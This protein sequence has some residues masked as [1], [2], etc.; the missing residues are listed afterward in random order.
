[1][2]LSA[3]W[4]YPTAF[5]CLLLSG[6]AGLVYQVV[7]ARYLGLVLGHASYA[8]V[9]VLVAFMGGLALG[10][11]WLG[12]YADRVRRPLSLYAWL[13]IG[14]A[15]YAL[16]FPIY[17]ERC[18]QM[19]VALGSGA[20]PGSPWLLA[21]KFVVSFALILLPT[22]L[23][24][25]T[26]PIL[27][28]LV[29]RSLGELRARVAGLYFINSLGAVFGVLLAEFW[30]IPGWGLDATL[31]GGATLN[32]AVGIIS[33][34]VASG[35]REMDIARLTSDSTREPDAGSSTTPA[36]D[37]AEEVYSPFELR[38]AIA[39][40][41]I[42]GFVAMLYEVV[43]TRVL[44]LVLGSST[45]A[46]S[47]MLVTFIAGITTG[48]W[49]VGRW[50]SLRRTFDA[51]GW[52][53]LALSLS[54]LVS[55]FFYHLLPYY[56]AK[57]GTMITRE[58]EH[59]WLYELG[60][61]TICFAVMFGPALCLGMTLPLAS[62]V[63]TS[64]LARTGRSVGVVFSVNTVGTVLGAALSGLVF[65]PWLGL[66][67]TFALGVGLNLIIALIVLA[68]RN[69][70]LR[71]VLVWTSPLV[72]L[73]LVGGVHRTLS[74]DWER[75]F[76]LGL[77]RETRLPPSVSDYV[78]GL[79]KVNVRF[80]R[81]GAG[82]TVV[83]HGWTNP[84]SR[85][86]EITLR[87]NGKADASSRGDVPTQLLSG[88]LPVLLKGDVKDVMVVGIGS[89]MTCG[90]ILTH[91]SV[92]TID[93]VEIS[94]EVRDAA[95][96]EFA[97]FNHG[98]LDDPR[99]R[100]VLD[101]AKSFLATSGR[102]YD[103]IVSEP[104]NPWMA[105]VAGVFSLEYYEACR[106]SL[107]AGGLMAQWVQTYE[108]ND[109]T[110]RMVLATFTS[111]FPFASVWQPMSGDLILIGSTSRLPR[112][113]AALQRRFD[114]PSVTRDLQRV[115]I[116]RLPVLL[117]LQLI[118]ED[119]T[120]FIAGEDTPRHSDFFPTLEYLAGKAFFVRER[121]HL[122]ETLD[123]TEL[124]RPGT[125]LGDYIK[126]HP[127]NLTDA[128]SYA[129]LHTS[130]GIPRAA[131][132]RSI[133]EL[134]RQLAPGE[135][136]PAEY[137]AKL[138]Y[139]L[140]VSELEAQ[141]MAQA[142]DAILTNATRQVEPLRIY[143]RHLMHAYRYLRSAYYIPPHEELKSVLERLVELDE[144][145]RRSHLLRLAEIAW[146]EGDDTN[147]FRLA[148]EAFRPGQD[149]P[150]EVGR[151]NFDNRAP[152]RV[153]FLII[154]TLW[155]AQRFAEARAWCEAARQGGFLDPAGQYYTER[156][157]MVVRKVELTEGQ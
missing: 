111:V 140:P 79:K 97:P 87:V 20:T 106:A 51:F 112:D 14:I 90:A 94:P 13:E 78:D 154:E 31:L 35:T 151:F 15:V 83:V 26:L 4:L 64:E 110:L 16:C 89:G 147:F 70:S 116:F 124:A 109:D 86:L 82:S 21:L 115:D 142:R 71:G 38:L 125:L 119:N 3:R 34:F 146:D 19:Y 136:L 57:I 74:K 12:R 121:S 130:F 113:I 93:A 39:A 157:S 6:A 10:N 98:A 46:F 100:V 37:H 60:Q 117:S 131:R 72:V 105:G 103:V 53:E 80:H 134:W 11:A 122:C 49:I 42:S 66:A 44:A 95:R 118:S 75:S 108:T 150:N 144:H 28:R 92:Q 126:L 120:A 132:L 59:Y 84:V 128:Q 69:P 148:A 135:S 99:V 50:R 23:M 153:L 55:M 127:L 156:L 68:R 145:H 47:I 149:G 7:W 41:G 33:L 27:T 91:P 48:A 81:D 129:L 24:G 114:E 63:A 18:Q 101:D 88:H 40:A 56:F 123:E 155:R 9:A 62:R 137:S 143:S 138:D 104:S 1:M 2:K 54:V 107:R 30:W 73:G 133:I 43:W 85:A 17:F 25:G 5:V 52:A 96:T 139:P 102:T 58:P 36:A 65:L 45:H 61:L 141:R 152:G 29:T 77:W 76:S 67:R 8:V 32:V 22:T